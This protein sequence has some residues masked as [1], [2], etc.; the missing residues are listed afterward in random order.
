MER[1]SLPLTG[2][3]CVTRIYTSLA[4]LDVDDGRFMLVEKLGALSVDELQKVTG[5]P[6]NIADDLKDLKVPKL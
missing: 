3:G 2:V 1:C 6:L 4:V 5:A